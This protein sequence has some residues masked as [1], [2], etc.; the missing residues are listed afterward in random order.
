M[1]GQWLRYYRQRAGFTIDELAVRI[2]WSRTTIS[3][4]ETGKRAVPAE[5]ILAYSRAC[6]APELIHRVRA[7]CLLCRRE[8]A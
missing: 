2:H 1:I 3:D 5:V 4:W 6:D 7:E 8:A